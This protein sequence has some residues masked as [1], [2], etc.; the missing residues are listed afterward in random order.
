M[1]SKRFWTD[2]LERSVRAAL[3]V[4]LTAVVVDSSTTAEATLTQKLYFGA[5]GALMSMGL[6]LLSALKGSENASFVLSESPGEGE[7]P[8][9]PEAK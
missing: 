1:L 3:I 8:A 4:F 7:P 9:P 6:S 5:T 2:F